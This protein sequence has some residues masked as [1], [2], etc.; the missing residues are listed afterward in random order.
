MFADIQIESSVHYVNCWDLRESSGCSRDDEQLSLEGHGGGEGGS[1]AGRDRYRLH[2]FAGQF[3]E[4]FLAPE[5]LGLP[6]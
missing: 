2:L 4:S 6:K 3:P 1:I 5:K